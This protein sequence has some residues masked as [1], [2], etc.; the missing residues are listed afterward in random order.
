MF[1]L[2][3]RASHS[4]AGISYFVDLGMKNLLMQIDLLNPSDVPALLNLEASAR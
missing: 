3:R 2:H 4:L 1:R